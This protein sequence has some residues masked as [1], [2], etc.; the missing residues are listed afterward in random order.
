MLRCEPVTGSCG[1]SMKLHVPEETGNLLISWADFGLFFV[2]IVT[3]YIHSQVHG[4]GSKEEPST[5]INDW[6]KREQS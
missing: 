4:R 1:N 5:T 3:K 6:K 2:T